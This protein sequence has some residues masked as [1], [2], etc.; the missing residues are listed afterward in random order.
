MKCRRWRNSTSL[1]ASAVRLFSHSKAKASRRTCDATAISSATGTD[2]KHDSRPHPATN[3]V[4]FYHLP[5]PSAHSACSGLLR[6]WKTLITV[7]TEMVLSSWQASPNN[8]SH[9]TSV[10]GHAWNHY[11]ERQVD[12]RPPTNAHTALQSSEPLHR[13]TDGLTPVR[14]SP[15]NAHTV[16]QSS[17]RSGATT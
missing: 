7:K 8:N 16:L 15:N 5:D 6:G 10:N 2:C 9:C 12:R 11:T 3:G 17:D 4:D 1:I 13:E 14:G